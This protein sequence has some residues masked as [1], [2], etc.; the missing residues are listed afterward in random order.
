MSYAVKGFVYKEKRILVYLKLPTA[1]L[2]QQLVL[3]P[4]KIVFGILF[5]VD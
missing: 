3:F 4:C 2:V 1:K 5:D